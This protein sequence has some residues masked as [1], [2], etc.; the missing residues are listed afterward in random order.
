MAN[1]GDLFF[2][3]LADGSRLASDIERQGVA[4]AKRAGGAVGA[5]L[6]ESMA[7][8]LQSRGRAISTLGSSMTR[9]LTLPIVGAGAAITAVG[10]DFDTTLRQIVALTDV[11]GDEIEGVKDDILEMSAALGKDPKELAEGFYFLASAGFDT[12]EAMEV[13]QSTAK[14]SAVGLGDTGSISAV[15]GAAINAFGKEN[16]TASDAVD[17]LIRAVNEGTAEASDF[18][19]AL[20]NVL[21]SAGQIGSSFSDVSA[22]IAAMTLK[23]ISADEA[24]TSLNQVFVSLIKTTPQAEKALDG[25]G[26]SSEGLRKQLREKGLLSVLETLSEKFEGNETAAAE[27]FGNIRAL[28]GIL[29]LTSGDAA[30]TASLFDDVANG[31]QNL[32]QAFEETEGPG[33]ETQRSMASVKATLIDLSDDVLPVVVDLLKQA[34]GILR[35]VADAFKGLPD[36]VRGGIVQVLAITAALGPLLFITGKVT[37]GLGSMLGAFGR[38]GRFAFG[39]RLAAPIAESVVAGAVDGVDSLPRNSRFSAATARVGKFLGTRLGGFIGAGIALAIA[40]QGARFINDRITDQYSALVAEGVGKG[41]VEGLQTLRASLLAQRAALPPWSQFVDIGG[42]KAANDAQ[43]KEVDDAILA[44]KA[45]NEAGGAAAGEALTDSFDRAMLSSFQQDPAWADSFDRQLDRTLQTG[46]AT[47]KAG[48]E[49]IGRVIPE[50]IADGVTKRRAVVG[51]AFDTLKDLM[52]NLLGRGEVIAR[53]VGILTSKALAR[54][55]SDERN[56]VRVEAQRVQAQAETE[57]AVLIGRGGK[58]GEKSMEKLRDGLRSKNPLIRESM[59]RVLAIVEA[60]ANSTIPAMEDA[61]EDAGRAYARA[62]LFAVRNATQAARAGLVGGPSSF[63]AAASRGDNGKP[64]KNGKGKARGGAITGPTWVNEHTPRTEMYVP[65]SSS[66]H[67][68]T[69]AAAMKAVASSAG[70]AG[71]TTINMPVSGALP[72]RTITDITGEMQRIDDSGFLPE[73]R[74]APLYLRKEA[75]GAG[76]RR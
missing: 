6:G 10:I 55:L 12:A 14:A 28:R 25:L 4:A 64:G 46:V 3:L 45:R 40:D 20:G 2:T 71:P 73:R 52:K 42:L 69:H 33:R 61:G 44:L 18:S 24:A 36:P 19:G 11:T 7:A 50:S 16:L 1:I 13:L 30:A 47:A 59:Q 72:V 49:E 34:A 70:G 56:A 26:L 67:I 75:A 62:L 23:G 57:L 51:D 29:A 43:L 35:T 37:S 41:S 60:G 32:A 8:G 5:T 31:T 39:S 54:G 74:V 76:A 48:G 21:G 68:L 9:S 65:S 66:G 15:V 53:D 17:Q 22:A 58:V 38:L 27:V 63:S